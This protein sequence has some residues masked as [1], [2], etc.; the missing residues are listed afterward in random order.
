VVPASERALVKPVGLGG[1][2]PPTSA[3]SVLRSN[4]L[5]Y[6]PEVDN[7]RLLSSNRHR[8]STTVIGGDPGAGWRGRTWKL[9]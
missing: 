2:E 1:L 9:L 8:C 6:S 7:L 3:L 4:Q 5:S